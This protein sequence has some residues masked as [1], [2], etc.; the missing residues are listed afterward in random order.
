MRKHSIRAEIGKQDH[1][2]KQ[3][4]I[5]LNKVNTIICVILFQLLGYFGFVVLAAFAF[6]E[7]ISKSQQKEGPSFLLLLPKA[8]HWVMSLGTSTIV[9]LIYFFKL[10]NYSLT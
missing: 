7:A 5:T 3:W 9:M 8:T 10:M 2:I 4:T 1:S 6:L